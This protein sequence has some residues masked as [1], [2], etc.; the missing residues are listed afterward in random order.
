MKTGFDLI[1]E[2]LL[3]ALSC[4]DT[5]ESSERIFGRWRVVAGPVITTPPGGGKKSTHWWV[6]CSCMSVSRLVREAKLKDGSSRGCGCDRD[7]KA[8]AI[9][10]THGRRYTPEY[11]V[12]CDMIRRCESPSFKQYK[13]YG[14]RGITVCAR[15]R[16]SFEAFFDDI[17]ERPSSGHSIDR[18]D[19]NGNYEP[20]N[21]RWATSSEQ[22]QNR[23]NSIRKSA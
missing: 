22:N 19:V 15:W 9:R 6:T 7:A 13:D 4:P 18:I 8:A 3:Q 5:D 1:A 11:R 20:G 12:W 2:I 17:G 10:T 21:V 14:G 23:R 16:T